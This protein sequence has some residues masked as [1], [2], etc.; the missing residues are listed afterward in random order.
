MH[1]GI[2]DAEHPVYPQFFGDDPRIQVGE[3]FEGRQKIEGV[4]ARIDG[5]AV[6]FRFRGGK[7]GALFHEGEEL[8][9]RPG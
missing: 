8:I 2:A 7:G 9:Q 4:F 6:Y 1:D 3:A 5:I